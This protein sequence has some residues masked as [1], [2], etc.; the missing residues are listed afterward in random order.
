LVKRIFCFALAHIVAIQLV[1][2][3][4]LAA[5]SDAPARVE[6]AVI[7]AGLAS[8]T[9]DDQSDPGLQHHGICTVCCVSAQ[10]TPLPVTAS[11]EYRERSFAFQRGFATSLADTAASRHDPRTSQGP[12][13]NA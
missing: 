9:N 6:F 13:P 3:V 4:P 1:L 10:A 11:V 8:S 2:S 12:P 5:H 7:C